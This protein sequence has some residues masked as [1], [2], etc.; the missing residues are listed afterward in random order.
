MTT[1]DH[2]I[3]MLCKNQEFANTHA[4]VD[5]KA[6][7]SAPCM[8]PKATFVEKA[9]NDNSN[10]EYDVCGRKCGARDNQ[11]R[12]SIMSSNVARLPSGQELSGVK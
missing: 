1:V 2:P 5:G 10:L 6:Y 8:T 9:D 7:L 4:S 3:N 12:E 11:T